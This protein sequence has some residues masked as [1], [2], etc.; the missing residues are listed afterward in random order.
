MEKRVYSNP[1]IP[2]FFEASGKPFK[3]SPQRNPETGQVEFLVQGKDLDQ[4][5]QELYSNPQI[6]I[7][8]Y[9]KALKYYGSVSLV[10]WNG[11]GGW[12]WD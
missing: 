10:R 8:D 1:S 11:A 4:A 12:D 7:L 6:G 3:I 5:L 2:A 9:L